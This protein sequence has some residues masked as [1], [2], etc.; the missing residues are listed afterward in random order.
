MRKWLCTTLALWVLI[1]GSVDVTAGLLRHRAPRC[2]VCRPL[3]R[4]R[5]RQAARKCPPSTSCPPA[6]ACPPAPAYPASCPSEAVAATCS[7]DPSAILD[8]VIVETPPNVHERVIDVPTLV[9]EQPPAVTTPHRPTTDEIQAPERIDAP[10]RVPSSAEPSPSASDSVVVEPARPSDYASEDAQPSVAIEPTDLVERTPVESATTAAVPPDNRYDDDPI[11]VAP[12]ASE[13]TPAEA[14]VQLDGRYATPSQPIES[15]AEAG[16]D[17][18]ATPGP[19]TTTPAPTTTTPSRYGVTPQPRLESSGSVE[20][21]DLF[22]SSSSVPQGAD[23]ADPVPSDSTPIVAEEAA[24]T[25]VAPADTSAPTEH[26]SETLDPKQLFGDDFGPSSQTDDTSDPPVAVESPAAP[27]TG[28]YDEVLQ[29]DIESTAPADEAN[30]VDADEFNLE[31][32]LLPPS[33]P[34]EAEPDDATPEDSLPEEDAAPTHEAPSIKNLFGDFPPHRVLREPGGIASAAPRTWHDASGRHQCAARLDEI[35]S[36]GVVLARV[37]GGEAHV[38]WR[39]LSDEDL[40]FLRRQ[41]AA[42]KEVLAR[43]HRG[44]GRTFVA[45]HPER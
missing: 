2:R 10:P 16:A 4:P 35:D 41:V 19:L 28:R 12:I 23:E 29:G 6:K 30:S 13:P 31:D 9:F 24:P 26:E 43:Q 38:A 37:E 18:V 36:S 3:I 39:Q 25:V 1:T 15:R 7:P 5:A 21:A 32:E 11:A 20:A 27:T 40:Q 44:E 22:G 14:P 17:A 42:K 33:T 45:S 8:S 34:Y